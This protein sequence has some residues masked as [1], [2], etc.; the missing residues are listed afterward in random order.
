MSVWLIIFVSVVNTFASDFPIRGRVFLGS[1][2]GNLSNVNKELKNLG[3]EEL[4]SI[5]FYGAEITYSVLPLMEVGINYL[6]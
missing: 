4:G 5:P 6:N 1:S 3:L 2:D